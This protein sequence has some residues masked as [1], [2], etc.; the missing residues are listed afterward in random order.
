MG[1]GRV[2]YEPGMADGGAMDAATGM[3]TGSETAT[4][5]GTDTG[6]DADTGAV[7]DAAMDAGSLVDG[8]A[9]LRCGDG[10]GVDAMISGRRFDPLGVDAGSSRRRLTVTYTPA[11]GADAGTATRMVVSVHDLTTDTWKTAFMSYGAAS[12]IQ[13]DDL[14]TEGHA[15][16]IGA[17]LDDASSY[18]CELTSRRGWLPV[19]LAF[20]TSDATFPLSGEPEVFTDCSAFPLVADF[21]QNGCISSEDLFAYVDAFTLPST[22]F[23]SIPGINSS[24]YFFY[25]DIYAATQCLCL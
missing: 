14:L 12:A 20:D 10:G 17:W 16:T 3:D 23:D 24:D 25:L 4:D 2:G 1:C 11:G 13:L 22:E 18:D 21:D 6:M 7:M 9:V 8:S 15:Y 5:A 19:A